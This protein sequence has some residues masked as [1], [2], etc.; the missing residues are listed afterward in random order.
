MLVCREMVNHGQK[1][2]SAQHV[3]ITGHYFTHFCSWVVL[4]DLV[5]RRVLD[6]GLQPSGVWT[7]HRDRICG[8]LC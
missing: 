8:I 7:E 5:L 6:Y 4:R 1:V 2:V 3:K